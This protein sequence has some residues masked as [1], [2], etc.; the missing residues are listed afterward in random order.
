M[1]GGTGFIAKIDGERTHKVV[2]LAVRSVANLT[3]RG[4]VLADAKSGDGAG[5]TIQLPP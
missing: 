1:A 5:V 3:H 2:E 4:A